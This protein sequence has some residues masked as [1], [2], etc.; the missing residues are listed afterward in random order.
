M[1][2]EGVGDF[3]EGTLRLEAGLQRRGR[4]GG[5]ATVGRSGHAPH[6]GVEGNQSELLIVEL[7]Q[8][9]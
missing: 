6:E 2:A 1:G 5:R 3:S 7:K 4:G 8:F 9:H